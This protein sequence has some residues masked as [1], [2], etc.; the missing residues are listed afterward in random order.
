[1]GVKTVNLLKRLFG[2]SPP[3]SRMRSV[4]VYLRAT[5]LYVVTIHGSGG[6][7]P[8]ISAGPLE[9]LAHD[10]H[11]EQLGDA[12]ARALARTT[13]DHPYPANQAEWQAVTAPLL[14]AAGVKT[15]R[16]FA[17]SASNLRVDEVDGALQVQ[18]C[19]RTKDSFSP[20]PERLRNLESPTAQALGALISEELVF[21]AARDGNATARS[22]RGNP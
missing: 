13:H 5:N 20:V 7:D 4:S 10:A 9:V 21:A 14:A 11:P 19:A 12:I 18:P 22:S 3:R 8:C 15:W 17:N 2:T 6:G 16:T 1:M